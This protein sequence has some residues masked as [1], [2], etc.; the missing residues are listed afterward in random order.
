MKKWIGILLV[1]GLLLVGGSFIIAPQESTTYIY[2]GKE[3]FQTYQEYRTFKEIMGVPEVTIWE[4]FVLSS[5]PPIVVD[6]RIEAPKG[7]DFPYGEREL[8]PS[9]LLF[10]LLFALGLVITLI[11]GGLGVAR[12]LSWIR[13]GI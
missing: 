6:Y 10:N 9:G 1:V 5:E 3:T 13:R 8:F 7:L 12:L 11:G 4:T 2:E